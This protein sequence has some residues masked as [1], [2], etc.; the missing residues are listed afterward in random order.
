MFSIKGYPM[1]SISTSENNLARS[2]NQKNRNE[3]DLCK[4]RPFQFKSE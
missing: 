2:I 4:C 3:K 1:I